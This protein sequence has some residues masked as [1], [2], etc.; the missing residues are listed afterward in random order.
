M[1][2]IPAHGAPSAPVRFSCPPGGTALIRPSAAATGGIR[3]A[4][5]TSRAFRRQIN[6][7]H[8]P[9]PARFQRGGFCG[10]HG[11]RFLGGCG[12]QCGFI[13]QRRHQPHQPAAQTDLFYL[14]LQRGRQERRRRFFQRMRVRLCLRGLRLCLR[15]RRQIKFIYARALHSLP[16][17]FHARQARCFGGHTP[18]YSRIRRREETH[19]PAHRGRRQWHPAGERQPRVP[20]QSDRDPDGARFIEETQCRRHPALLDACI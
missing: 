11:H 18:L 9:Q 4:A 6:Y 13:Y 1:S 20:L 7:N 15:R 17:R 2:T 19:S 14:P 10:E 5:K 3:G 16:N 12:R 8:A